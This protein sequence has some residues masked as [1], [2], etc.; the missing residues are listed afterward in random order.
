MAKVADSVS[1]VAPSSVA[2]SKDQQYFA[3]NGYVVLRNVVS[4]EKIDRLMELYQ[5]QILPSNVRFFRQN[6]FKYERNIINE[7]GFCKS[8][9]LDIHNYKLFPEFGETAMDI[10]LGDD[11]LDKVNDA[12]GY[13]SHNLM[14]TMLF[15]ANT[16]TWPHQDWWYLDSKPKAGQLVGAWF[17]L[18]DIDEDAGRFYVVPGSHKLKFHEEKNIG[19][20]E[21]IAKIGEFVKSNESDVQAPALKKGDVLV[22][23]SS[24]VHGSLPNKNPA[25]SRKSLTAHYLP[26]ELQYGNLFIDKPWIEYKE[27]DGKLFHA[28][29]PEYSLK[30]HTLAEV[31]RFLYGKPRLMA[32]A[33]K[34]QNKPLFN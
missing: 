2:V 33:R 9:L 5:K 13:S 21:W 29:Q 7:H 10:F 16:E 26:T 34:F 24:T 28:N 27:K 19:H 1:D 12:N 20:K 25:L 14:Q 30:N 6:S 32:L 3:D 11:V 23:A 22:W 31:K 15:D 17:A 4:E 8:S 18:E